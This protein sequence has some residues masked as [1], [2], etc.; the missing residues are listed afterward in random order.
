MRVLGAMADHDPAVLRAAVL[1]T[2]GQRLA[3]FGE[4][5]A[6][7]YTAA[8]QAVLRAGAGAMPGTPAAQAVAELVET[9]HAELLARFAPADLIGFHGHT[10]FHEPRGR[11]THQAGSGA[12]LAEVLAEAH[13]C[14]VVWD[15]R[16]TDL[17]MGGQGGPLLPFYQHALAVHLA[18]AAASGARSA[19]PVA[20]LHLGRRAWLCWCDTAEPDPAAGCIAMDVGPGPGMVTALLCAQFGPALHDAGAGD[21]AVDA[22]ALERLIA[23][24]WFARVPLRHQPHAVHEPRLDGLAGGDAAATLAAA[25]AARIVMALDHLPRMPACI[26]VTG[27]GRQDAALMAMLEAGCDC[28]V[29]PAEAA[30]LDPAQIPAQAIGYLAA[31]VARGLPTTGPG[32]TGVPAPV[33]G[34][35]LSRPGELLPMSLPG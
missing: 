21:G 19:G 2:D 28:P 10:L 18:D 6:R 13:G 4:T 32:T 20:F 26:R 17:R 16:S 11:G 33:G 8:E 3:G 1:F 5:A 24:P 23:H 35:T 14:P 15:F 25:L 34:G 12:I 22:A 29:S 30:G 9:A 27:P 31:R 7:P